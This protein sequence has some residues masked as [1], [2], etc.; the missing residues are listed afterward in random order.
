V[1]PGLIRVLLPEPTKECLPRQLLPRGI[2]PV[3]VVWVTEFS[4]L[5]L[6]KR[7]IM[8][9][10]EE[11]GLL[12]FAVIRISMVADTMLILHTTFTELWA[13]N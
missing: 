6:L 8:D 5:Q 4:P 9:Y 1:N 13:N 11:S 2:L 3:G 10:P 7:I 12:S